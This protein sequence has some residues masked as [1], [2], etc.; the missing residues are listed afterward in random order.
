MFKLAQTNQPTDQ[1]TNRPTNRQGKHNMSP[2]TIVGD[3]QMLKNELTLN[4]QTTNENYTADKKMLL[5]QHLSAARAAYCCSSSNSLVE[6]H[7]N[8]ARAAKFLL[9]QQY[10]ARAAFIFRISH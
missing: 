1:P 8:A 3:I 2:T 10:A 7:L 6:Q 5:E 9:E 4:C